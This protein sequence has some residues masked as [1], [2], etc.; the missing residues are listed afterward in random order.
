[1]SVKNPVGH[2]LVVCSNRVFSHCRTVPYEYISNISKV[3]LNDAYTLGYTSPYSEVEHHVAILNTVWKKDLL[4]S[5]VLPPCSSLNV[6]ISSI[7]CL[8]N[9]K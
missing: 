9:Y 2:Y 1:V 8:K 3:R 4:V 5:F 6:I 7:S